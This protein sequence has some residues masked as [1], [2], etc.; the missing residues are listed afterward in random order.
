MDRA[1]SIIYVLTMTPILI[2]V[3]CTAVN[4]SLGFSEADVRGK[5]LL[6]ASL[7]YAFS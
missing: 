5:N 3:K 7:A 6:T 4:C 1:I 2:P